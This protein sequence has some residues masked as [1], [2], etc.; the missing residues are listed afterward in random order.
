MTVS[1]TKTCLDPHSCELLLQIAAAAA[2]VAPQDLTPARRRALSRDANTCLMPDGGPLPAMRR[3]LSIPLPGRTLAARLYQGAPGWPRTGASDVLLVFFHGGGWVVGDLET[4]DNACAH[5]CRELGCAVLNI[6]YRKAPEHSFPAPCDDA[7]DAYAWAA[8]QLGN[9]G[10]T[11]LAVAGDSAGGHLAAHAMA[12]H[13]EL[14]TAAA[15]L[16]YPVAGMDFTNTSYTERASG[17]GLTGPS[18][19]WYWEQFLGSAS[20]SHDPRAV[21][22]HQQWRRIPPP[23]VV[24]LAWHDPL[25]DEGVAYAALLRGAGAQVQLLVAPDMAHGFL[26]QCRINAAAGGHVAQ[27]TQALLACLAGPASQ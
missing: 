24:S 25:H 20:P 7:A 3:E 5:L 8:E 6:A 4:H 22:L 15:L 13:P 12:V 9:F 17:P 23:T 10:C 27:A 18:M 14:D 21:L 26:R 11:R 1:D 2:A 16:F 19:V